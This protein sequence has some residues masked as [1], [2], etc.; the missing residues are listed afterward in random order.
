MHHLT[1]ARLKSLPAEVL[2]LHTKAVVA[3]ANAQ[4]MDTLSPSGHETV[5]HLAETLGDLCREAVTTVQEASALNS[6]FMLL[7]GTFLPL[8]D[9]RLEER[10]INRMLRMVHDADLGHVA[11]SRTQAMLLWTLTELLYT[12]PEF[13][14]EQAGGSFRKITSAWAA[15]ADATGCWPGL[16]EEEALLRIIIL[17]RKKY[18]LLDGSLDALLPRLSTHYLTSHTAVAAPLDETEARRLALRYIALSDNYENWT[19][20]DQARHIASLGTA[21]PSPAQH[22]DAVAVCLRSLQLLK[23]SEAVAV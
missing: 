16:C 12:L 15:Q 13:V 6:L 10:C 21:V 9:N 11:D 1:T 8:R 20:R 18:M 17:K 19:E 7:N 3:A 14:E 2:L 22:D 5:R 4:G 23:T